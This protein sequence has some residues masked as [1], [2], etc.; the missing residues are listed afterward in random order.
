MCQNLTK[1]H[2]KRESK[3]TKSDPTEYSKNAREE[4]LIAMHKLLLKRRLSFFKNQ[5][6][7]V[8]YKQGRIV[9]SIVGS[10]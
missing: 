5:S 9:G 7:P 3:W 6:D 1:N 4:R 8:L 10:K 2:A